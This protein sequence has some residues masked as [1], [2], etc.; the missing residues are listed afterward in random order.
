[1]VDNRTRASVQGARHLGIGFSV[2]QHAHDIRRVA[3][4]TLSAMTPRYLAISTSRPRP[5]TP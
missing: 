1:M 5:H 4:A 3:V 2:K